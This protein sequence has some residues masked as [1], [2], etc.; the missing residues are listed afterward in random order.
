MC[1]FV[2]THTVPVRVAVCVEATISISDSNRKQLLEFLDVVKG[3][4]N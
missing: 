1:V 3:V 2:F 4:S